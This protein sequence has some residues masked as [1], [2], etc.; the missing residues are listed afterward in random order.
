MPIITATVPDFR[1]GAFNVSEVAAVGTA[2]YP[3][4]GIGDHETVAADTLGA[5]W[6]TLGYVA[7]T[8]EVL[9]EGVEFH[10]TSNSVANNVIMSAVGDGHIY[11]VSQRTGPVKVPMKDGFSFTSANTGFT[12]HYRIQRYVTTS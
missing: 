6:A 10:T 1:Q 12:I 2:S 8:F 11:A 9:I 3:T 5:H 4:D 7:G